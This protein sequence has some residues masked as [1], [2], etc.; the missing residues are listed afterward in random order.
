MENSPQKE[1][2]EIIKRQLPTGSSLVNSIAKTLSMSESGAYKKI[3]NISKLSFEEVII[4]CKRYG[5]SFDS[6]TSDADKSLSPYFFYSDTIRYEPRSYN[7]FL[8]GF[9]ESSQNVRSHERKL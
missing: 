4:L 3:T 6:F 1:F 7:E 2:F 9:L 5:I 8:A